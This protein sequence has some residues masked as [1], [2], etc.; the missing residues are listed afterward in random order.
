MFRPAAAADAEEAFRWYEN[1]RPGLGEEFLSEVSRAIRAV[2]ENPERYPVIHRRTRRAL[3][4]R[5]PY[6]IFYQVLEG[7]L[8]IVACFHAKR[9]P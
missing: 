4:S 1:R 8:V 5:F 7:Q 2:M 3:V 6:G 9:N